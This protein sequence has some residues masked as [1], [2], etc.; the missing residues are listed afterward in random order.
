M[1]QDPLDLELAT[2]AILADNHDVKGLLEMLARQLSATLGSKVTVERE[3]GILR[4]SK[5][6]RALRVAFGAKTFVAEIARGS[7]VTAIALES[8]GIR[9]RT[10]KVEMGDWL[11]GLLAEL[12][13]AASSNQASR[14]ALEQIVN[15]GRPTGGI[16]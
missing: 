1:S 14:M 11:A 6:I 7:L 3:G 16:L 4:K 15:G 5:E 2:T 8:G 13:V 12:Q 10:D 9:I